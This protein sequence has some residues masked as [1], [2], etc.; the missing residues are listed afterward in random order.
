MT[1]KIKTPFFVVNPKNFLFGENLM[2][3]AHSANYL[4]KHYEVTILFTAPHTELANIVMNCP[5]LIV[6]AQHM[7]CV[8]PGDSM[9]YVLAESL[10]YIG[11][12]VVVLNHADNPM[13]LTTI[14]KTIQRAK[15]VGLQTIVCADTAKEAKAIAIFEPDIILAEPTNLIGRDQKSDRAYV[16]STIENIKNVNKDILVEQGAGIRTEH[17]VTELLLL[18]ADGIGVTSG[19]VKANNPIE[20]MEKMIQAVALYQKKGSV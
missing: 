16:T 3:L 17:D 19:I 2:E 1:R 12:E 10:R 5:N 9:G 7:D 15:E 18:G 4:A 13:M 8:V 6:T 20:M 14:G 11:V